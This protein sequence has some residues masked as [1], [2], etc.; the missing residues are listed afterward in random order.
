MKFERRIF[1]AEFRA[2]RTADQPS[3][4]V[5]YASVFNQPSGDLGGF[6]EVI[7]P[8]AFTRTLAAGADVRALFNHD[9]NFI[10]GRTQDGGKTGTLRLSED[11]TGLKFTVDMPDTQV[12]RDLLVSVERGDIS[13]NSFGFIVKQ[14]TRSMVKGADGENRMVREITDCD[15]FDVSPVTYPAYTQTTLEARSAFLFPNGMPEELTELMSEQTA[16]DTALA[17]LENVRRIVA[18]LRTKMIKL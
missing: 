15:L 14:Q 17:A 4:L 11:A 9:P 13:Q 12:G 7:K 1:N 16:D 18:Q 6:I 3:Q 5:G 8:G 2:V 10:I